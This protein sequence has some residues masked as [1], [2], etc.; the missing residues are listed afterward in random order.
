MWLTTTRNTL[1]RNLKTTLVKTI[2]TG[3]IAPAWDSALP[4]LSAE[5][6]NECAQLDEELY[7]LVL[8]CLEI[9]QSTDK[10]TEKQKA[11]ARDLYTKVDAE[12]R[13]RDLESGI[14]AIAYIQRVALGETTSENASAMGSIM[15]LKTR[16]GSYRDALTML[17]T[18]RTSARNSR[19]RSSLYGR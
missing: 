10:V 1:P 7:G 3:C 11:D 4:W 6:K 8:A 15:T 5:E 18:L 17:T 12:M 13:S 19:A 2:E 9:V 14:A 16:G